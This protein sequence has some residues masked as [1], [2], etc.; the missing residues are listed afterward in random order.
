MKIDKLKIIGI[1]ATVAGVGANILASWVGEKQLDDK[2][3]AKAAEAV[4]N[5]SKKD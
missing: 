1:V 5:L 3:A 2:I 4:A